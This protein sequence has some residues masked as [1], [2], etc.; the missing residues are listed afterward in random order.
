M[1]IRKIS[2]N[3]YRIDISLG[4]DN[5]GKQKRHQVAFD[6]TYENAVIYE[7]ELGRQLGR[8]SPEKR[9][10]AGFVD[11]Y[12]QWAHNHLSEKTCKEK[13]KNIF[14]KLLPFFGNMKPDF[15]T[16]NILEAYQTKRLKESGSKI[17]RAINIELGD[18]STIVT[19]AREHGYC[20]DT[21]AQIKPLPYKRPIPSILSREEMQTFIDACETYDKALFYVLYH[22]GLRN[23]EIKIKWSDVNFDRKF[24]RVVGK[25]NKERLIPFT[26]SM[27]AALLEL[28]DEWNAKAPENRSEWVFRSR[29]HREM[30]VKDIRKIIAS[31]KEKSGIT[32][33]ITPHMLRHSFAT[34]LLDDGVDLRIIQILLGHEDIGTT[35]IYT[36]VGMALKEK[37][38]GTFNRKLGTS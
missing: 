17:H 35:Q 2:E 25:G 32:R 9:T 31:A 18:L 28:L 21:L 6:G 11:E 20:I 27:E 15:I 29:R 33:R 3:K 37:A 14:G 13:K 4:Y 24:I 26:D 5:E 10:I 38:V 36:K 12:L 30:P 16:K 1:A 7:I 8:P 23:N 22:G 19:W 34:H